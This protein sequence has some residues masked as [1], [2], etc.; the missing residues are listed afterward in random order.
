MAHLRYLYTLLSEFNLMINPAKYQFGLEAVN[1]LGH[2]ITRDGATPLPSKV[3]AIWFPSPSTTKGLQ[4]FMGM[5]NFY[6][7]F[8][9]SAAWIMQPLFAQIAGKAK[10]ITWDEESAEAFMKA[11]KALADAALLAHPRTDTLWALTAER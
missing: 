3:E 1:F 7:R 9:P 8:I 4:E 2:R 11:K 10:V 6:H 5:I